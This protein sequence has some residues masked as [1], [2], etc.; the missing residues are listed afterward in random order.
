MTPVV[1]GNIRM[2]LASIKSTRWRSSFTMLGVVVAVVPVLT[3]LGIG[4]GVKRQIS[5][6]IN[7][8]GNNLIT[9][10]PG[11]LA[12]SD[13]VLVQFNS[14]NGYS[15]SGTFS[16]QDYAALSHVKSVD[17]VAPLSI[18][19]GTVTVNDQTFKDTFVVG[20]TEDLPNLINHKVQYGEFFSE[21]DYDR[22]VAV[23]GRGAA[24]H[25]FG[26]GVPLGRAFDFHGETFIVRGVL[27]RFGSTPL[28]F[29]ANLNDAVIL[30]YSVAKRLSNGGTI[31]EI[32]ARS[33]SQDDTAVTVNDIITALQGSRGGEKDFS[34][35]TQSENLRVVNRILILLTALVS[36]VAGIALLVSGISIM[37]IML[38]TVTERMHEIGIRKAIGATKRQIIGQFMAEAIILSLAGGLIG[39]ALSFLVEYLIRVTTSLQPVITLQAVVLVTGLS[40]A[41][42]A[43]FGSIPALKAARK[44]PIDALRYE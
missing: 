18:V 22:R 13:N 12:D 27:E 38:V 34:V 3:I 36:G 29:N 41:V 40:L 24:E 32:L 42:G 30:P 19:P 33:T 43:I 5:H 7:Q 21:Q 37:N 14:L 31:N 11:K 6:E 20:S 17:K 10:R 39:V 16:N 23:V 28:S 15:T 25:L 1:R 44:D 4:E 2:A 9:V 8:L 26:E 35:L